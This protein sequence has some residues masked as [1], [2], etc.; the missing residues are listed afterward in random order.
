[1]AAAHSIIASVAEGVRQLGI[2]C[3]HKCS[4]L[5]GFFDVPFKGTYNK[6]N[7]DGSDLRLNFLVDARNRFPVAGIV[8]HAINMNFADRKL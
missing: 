7:L 4:V 5:V 3:S 1:M 8:P 6:L 2:P